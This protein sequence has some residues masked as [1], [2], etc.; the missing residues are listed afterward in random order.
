MRIAFLDA[1][2]ADLTADA[3]YE[4][5]VG[6]SHSAMFYLS[7]ELARLG[8][9]V[10]I[11]NGTSAPGEYRGVACVHHREGLTAQYLNGFDV[12]VALNSACGATLKREIGVRVPLVLWNQHA[13]DQPP[14]QELH[15]LRERKTWA[16]FAFVSQWQLD[17]FV[18]KFW[19]PRE[20]S[21]VLRNAAGPAFAGLPPA[22]PWFARGAAPV[23]VYTSTPFRGLD[24]LLSAFPLIRAAIPDVRLRVFSSMALYQ[25]RPEDDKYRELYAR[26]AATE[27]AEYVGPVGQARLARELA[28]AAALA[29]PST[30]AETSCIAV[31]EAMAAGA[32]VFTTRLGALPETAGGF[33]SMVDPSDDRTKLAGSFAGMVADALAEMRRESAA[34]AERRE[35]Q[36]AFIRQNYLWPARAAEWQAWLSSLL[37]A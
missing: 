29:Y 34:A 19:V 31:I 37:A 36:L 32:A 27:G 8:H 22:V 1:S 3:P 26:C 28:E 11:V 14:V 15:R 5:P 21:I 30:F 25:V 16:G 24:V 4:R 7:V 10:A 9:T 20:K 13:F 6:G 12:V 18:E 17:T 23:L 33:A 2:L 35:A